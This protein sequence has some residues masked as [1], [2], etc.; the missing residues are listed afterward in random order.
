M[1]SDGGSAKTRLEEPKTGLAIGSE[2][3]PQQEQ[4][5][6]HV[7]GA[8]RFAAWSAESEE[9]GCRCN[10]PSHRSQCG[11]IAVTHR[12]IVQHNQVNARGHGVRMRFTL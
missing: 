7:S 12:R 5:P 4:I 6:L 3:N 8:K 11:E 2:W 10:G 1:V 9:E